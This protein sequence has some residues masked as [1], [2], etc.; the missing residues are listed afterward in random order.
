MKKPDKEI[1]KLLLNRYQLQAES[2]VFID[3]N[4][5]NIKVAQELGFGTVH[6][7]NAT[8]LKLELVNMNLLE[9]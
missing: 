6:I 2:S 5:E 9:S 4:A 3:D 1:Y 8:D 7:N